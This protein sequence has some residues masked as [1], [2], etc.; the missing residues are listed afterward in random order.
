MKKSEI[1]NALTALKSIKMPKIES[2]DFRNELIADHIYLLGQQ[3]KL[4]SDAK[5]LEIAHLGAYE[6]ERNKVA[7]LQQKFQSEKDADKR[8]ALSDEINSHTEL[9]KAVL[10][11]NKAVEALANEEIALPHLFEANKFVEAMEG[12]DYDLSLVE[13]VFPMLETN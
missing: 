13:A 4:E 11:Y 10:G 9:F 12:Q 1:K 5:D 7:E 6:D 3:K 2:K 8:K